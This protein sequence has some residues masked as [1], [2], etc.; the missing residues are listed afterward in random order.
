MNLRLLLV[1]C[2]FGSD[3]TLDDSETH[4]TCSLVI[5][6]DKIDEAFAAVRG[7]V[8][9]VPNMGKIEWAMWAN[10]QA[11]AAGLSEYQE[12]FLSVYML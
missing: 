2:Q 4:C 1:F 8:C 11:L 3:L 7:S 12:T 9:P 6:C 5:E 10:E